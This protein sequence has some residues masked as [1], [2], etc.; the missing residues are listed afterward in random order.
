ML[1]SL[2]VIDAYGEDTLAHPVGTGA[3]KLDSWTRR[4]KIVL[5]ATPEYRGFVYN[6]PTYD[7]PGL[8]GFDRTT[9]RAEPSIG[10]GYRF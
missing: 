5:T 7:V 8:S 2:S 6:S 3:Y 4:A 10:F 9:H 1:S